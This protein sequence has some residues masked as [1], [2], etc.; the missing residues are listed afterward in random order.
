MLEL[1]ELARQQLG[2]AFDLR[3]FNDQILIRGAVPLPVLEANIKTWI[4]QTDI[5]H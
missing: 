3:A 1:R 4:A 5:S 2:D